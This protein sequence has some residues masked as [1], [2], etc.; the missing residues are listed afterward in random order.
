[1]I[2][3]DNAT[4]LMVLKRIL[5]SAG[6]VVTATSSGREALAAITTGDYAAAVIDMHMPG[7]DGLAVVRQFRRDHPRSTL[8][9]IVVTADES[10]DAQSGSAD[11]GADAYLNKPVKPAKL[12]ST[13]KQVLRARKVVYLA[14][15]QR[16]PEGAAPVLDE[17]TF[18]EIRANLAERAELD[19]LVRIFEG[20]MEQLLRG[21]Q[22]AR[23]DSDEKSLGDALAAARAAAL[24]IG[25]FRLA[26]G[27]ETLKTAVTGGADIDADTEVAVL[28]EEYRAAVKRLREIV[29]R[30]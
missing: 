20:E 16:V 6:Y 25:A 22:Q 23:A 30:G 1:L 2:V 17:D 12:L 10:F 4:N 7:F 18:R 21:I 8:A 3:D 27:C 24:S 29:K 14:R 9:I 13:I 28:R 26:K 5:L 19:T 11:A 15:G